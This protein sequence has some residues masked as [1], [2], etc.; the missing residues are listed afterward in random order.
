MKKDIKKLKE[1]DIQYEKGDPLISDTEYDMFKLETKLQHPNDP[2]FKTV[3]APVKNADVKHSYI[4]GSLNKTKPD[5]S[6]LKWARNN[7]IKEVCISSKLDGVSVFI[8]VENGKLILASTRGDGYEGKDITSKISNIFPVIPDDIS[9]KARSEAVMIPLK[10]KEL[11]YKNS[12]NAVAGILNSDDGENIEY[13][14]L[15][16]YQVFD[17]N[18]FKYSDHFDF[19]HN[20]NLEIP[21]HNTIQVSE[22]I[23]SI[24]VEELSRIKEIE[25][26]DVDGI[27]VADNNDAHIGEDYYPSNISAFKV[28]E[29][30]V[31]T[32]VTDIKWNVGRSGKLTPV[33]HIEPLELNGSTVSKATG[34][35]AAFIE[36]SNIY[37]GSTVGIV[38]SGD[39]IP[40]ITECKE[41]DKENLTLI[42]TNCPSCGDFLDR[43]LTNID[44]FCLN[45]NCPQKNLYKI[46]NFLLAHE[47][48]E[49]SYTTLENLGVKS[50]YD[51]YELDEFSISMMEGFGSRSANII[52]KEINKTLNTTPEKL[53]KSFGI[54]GCGDSISKSIMN[55]FSFDELFELNKNDLIISI[56]GIGNILA[57]NIIKGLKNNKELYDFLISKGLKFKETSS[58][59]LK[60][61]VFALTGKSDMKRNDVISLI[62]SNGGMVKGMSKTVDYLVTNDVKSNSSKTRKAMEYGTKIISYDDLLEMLG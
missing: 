23:E 9:F 1:Y 30:A 32:K 57:N 15:I 20:I 27:V 38:K 12:R 26:F 44:L 45:D 58:I 10:A 60:G 29:D 34:F 39:I 52:I 18:F 16:F 54:S 37:I 59:N 40:Y 33:V 43:S 25:L 51:L 62:A 28:N 42:P 41:K 61:K 8:S 7:N 14:N 21:I 47:C 22:D 53:L 49:I 11:G 19:L 35:N 2:Y 4:L 17:Q 3:G 48:E 50:I 56:Y 5:G 24:L 13:I 31:F 6:L 46:E 55:K 36:T